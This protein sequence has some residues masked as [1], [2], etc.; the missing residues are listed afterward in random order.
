MIKKLLLTI[1]IILFA[2]VAYG[3]ND[4][5]NHLPPRDSTSFGTKDEVFKKIIIDVVNELN[6]ASPRYKIYKTQ[7]TYNLIRLDTATGAVW[8]VQ[9]R[10]GTSQAMILEI[11][12]TSLLGYYEKEIP[13][14]FELYET[15]NMY[16][17]LLIDTQ[18][19]RVWQVQWNTEGP[20]KRFRERIYE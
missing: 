16:T 2:Y 15:N 7:N 17:Y 4:G 6:I 18:T 13:G 10:M 11:D 19:G 1:A 9:Y 14:R 20:S 8:Q 12:E 3:Q 5:Q